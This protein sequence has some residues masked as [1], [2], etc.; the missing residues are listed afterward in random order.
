MK[1]PPPAQGKERAQ[2]AR[3]EPRWPVALAILAVL[4]V[5]TWLSSR[6]RLFPSWVAYAIGIAPLL[7]I[8]GVWL[9]G[10]QAR[11]L[12]IERITT[13]CFSVIAE[14][15]TLAMLSF[16]VLGMLDRPTA[17]S[18]RQLLTSSIGAW[19][20]NILAFS[21]VYWQ[22]DRGGP[23]AW[24]NNAILKPD[25]LFPQSAASEEAPPD[26]RPTFVDY[27][28]LSFSTATAFSPTDALPLTSR[29]KMLMMI[30]ST[31]S[32]M[33]LVIVASRAINILGS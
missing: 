23:E 15:S 1:K 8:V 18:G 6:A 30:E 12:R 31:V 7:P 2:P 5:L 10:A 22:I 32:L 13:L 25:W 20:T 29:A 33:T 9:S 17:F 21:L 16:L 24:A 14:I 11:W 27:W 4:F 19:L 26:W 3:L 28:F